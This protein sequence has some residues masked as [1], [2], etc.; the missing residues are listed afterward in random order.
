MRVAVLRGR[1]SSVPK[2]ANPIMT[3][4]RSTDGSAPVSITKN[5][6][7]EM[8]SA[9][10]PP[11]DSRSSTAS[12]SIG[13]STIATLPPETATRWPSPVAR[14]CSAVERV[15]PRRVAE[16]EP[17][18][19]P[20][21]P[22]R[23]QVEEVPEQRRPHRLG[24]ADERVRGWAEPLRLPRRERDRD[25]LPRQERGEPRVP[26]RLDGPLDPDP[27]ARVAPRGAGPKPSTQTFSEVP[28]S[29]VDRV[30][31]SNAS[32]RPARMTAD[33]PRSSDSGSVTSDPSTVTPRGA[34][35]ASRPVSTRSVV[36][37]RPPG[38][39]EHG[40]GDHRGE[41]HAGRT[42]SRDA[43]RG[44]DLTDGVRLARDRQAHPDEGRAGRSHRREPG[45]QPEADQTGQQQLPDRGDRAERR[46]RQDPRPEGAGQDRGEPAGHRFRP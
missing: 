31:G 33:Q 24:G 42:A 39:Q 13:A 21:P 29:S 43:R 20:G 45:R 44:G 5:T 16:R 6:T 19:Q 9:N 8:P 27:V 12:P 38:A 34:S 11:A 36:E 4:A 35:V 26:G 1:P 10:R 40:G 22:F 14:K 41:H 17:H 32:T 18:E 3:P 28:S 46:P 15:E 25:P 7:V 37:P 2:S 30:T 23:E